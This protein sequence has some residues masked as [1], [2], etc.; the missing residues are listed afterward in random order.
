MTQDL[1]RAGAPLGMQPGLVDQA[2]AMRVRAIYGI[3]VHASN[4]VGSLGRDLLDLDAARGTI[5]RCMRATGP[6]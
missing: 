5:P 6:R 4:G 3:D 2:F 1:R